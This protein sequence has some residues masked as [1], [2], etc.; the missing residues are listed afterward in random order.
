[1]K[2]ISIEAFSELAK[3]DALFEWAEHANGHFYG[4]PKEPQKRAG[5]R[6]SWVV[7]RA[8]EELYPQPVQPQPPSLPPH[9]A[10]TPIISASVD[11]APSASAA[12]PVASAP[13]PPQSAPTVVG[14]ALPNGSTSVPA[15]TSRLVSDLDSEGSVDTSASGDAPAA[16]SSAIRRSTGVTVASSDPKS[17][18]AAPSDAA[19]DEAE[20]LCGLIEQMQVNAV[21]HRLEDEGAAGAG[22][23][24]EAADADTSPSSVKFAFNDTSNEDKFVFKAESPSLKKRQVT[25]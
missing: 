7:V 18:A 24:G 21:D 9:V 19:G 10:T 25:I 20:A 23:S 22:T 13:T 17:D 8:I 6:S 4:L 12:A 14:T 3:K 2:H 16:G 1:M 11:E 5:L 15:T